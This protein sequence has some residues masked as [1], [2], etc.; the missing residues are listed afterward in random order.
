MY[1]NNH[2]VWHKYDAFVDGEHGDFTQAEWFGKP[3]H[4]DEYDWQR[5]TDVV[6]GYEDELVPPHRVDF[7][8][9]GLVKEDEIKA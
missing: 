3:S 4:R 5:R 7:R 9:I 1:Y 8:S 6:M 2:M